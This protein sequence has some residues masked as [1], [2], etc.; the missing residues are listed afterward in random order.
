M[1]MFDDDL[2]AMFGERYDSGLEGCGAEKE[3][4]IPAQMPKMERKAFEKHTPKFEAKP[5]KRKEIPI[6]EYAPVAKTEPSLRD[7][8]IGCVKWA[9]TFGGLNT[10]IFYWQLA[11]L[12]DE[13]IAVPC[14]WVCC[15]LA[16]FGVG[17]NFLK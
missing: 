9:F 11:G 8:L 17:K 13:S 7:R 6:S 4:E 12:M 2:Q 15:F 16:G 14:M 5:E 3:E 10:L 1:D